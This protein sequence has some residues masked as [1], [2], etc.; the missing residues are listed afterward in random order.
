M[1]EAFNPYHQWLGYP[2]DFQPGDDYALL[3]LERFESDPETIR[4]EADVLMAQVRRVR[5]GK[6]AAQWAKL[7]DDLES[8][9]SRLMDLQAKAA[10]DASLESSQPVTGQR[11]AYPARAP[12]GAEDRAE[13][14]AM[15]EQTRAP[16]STQAISQPVAAP[17]AGSQAVPSSAPG[18]EENSPVFREVDRSDIEE[19]KPVPRA[20]PSSLQPQRASQVRKQKAPTGKPDVIDVAYR[21]LAVATLL[22]A[23][24]LAW[25]VFQ[26]HEQFAVLLGFGE[27]GH[28]AEAGA[29]EPAQPPDPQ[30]PK[31]PLASAPEST[32]LATSPPPDATAAPIDDGTG[33][34]ASGEAGP[35]EPGVPQRPPV[36][37]PDDNRV[38]PAAPEPLPSSPANPSPGQPS[39]PT[40]PVPADNPHRAAV[41][42]IWESLAA[43]DLETARGRLNS[44]A[45]TVRS[46]D[47]R[48]LVRGLDSLVRYLEQFWQRMASVVPTLAA[49]EEFAI[50]DT[51]VVVVDGTREELTIRAAGRNRTYPI[52]QIP[53][54]LVR[55]IAQRHFGN[56]VQSQAMYAAY[57]AV[58]PDGDRAQAQR[59]WEGAQQQGLDTSDLLAV[60]EL[61]PPPRG[62]PPGPRAPEPDATAKAQAANAI[63][64]EYAQQLGEARTPT[65]RR[66]LAGEFLAAA[67]DEE[68]G[69]PRQF[70]FYQFARD[71]AIRAGDPETAALAVE[72]MA[73]A[74]EVDR[75]ALQ[76]DTFQQLAKTAR[77]NQAAA[78]LA[79]YAL[80]ATKSAASDSRNEEA[81][82][83]AQ[84]ALSAAQR[85]GNAALV[86]QV[87]GTLQGLQISVARD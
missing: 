57:L 9:K 46:P 24:V 37:P 33:G 41:A 35:A 80:E 36:E 78:Q 69:T 52:R 27:G 60:L 50:G 19:P 22:C 62:E 51:Y 6:H 38:E 47:D 84:V 59:I 72:G 14:A 45:A 31:V 12:A 81:H 56:D 73:D 26:R 54:V 71:W 70:V 64:S 77:S 34:P 17:Q 5:P 65:A 48:G 67:R 15:P 61:A 49:G 1:T 4:R 58:E 39:P 74:F 7:L 43:R 82:T 68:R 21:V 20:A 76:A 11:C 86:R 63:S 66:R 16:R 87:F 32:E 25:L 29:G 53:D 85:S 13:S 83:L 28:P 3:G 42:G 10:Y 44:L 30:V 79:Q 2:P 8:A 55:M 40:Q 18:E 23:I 75:L